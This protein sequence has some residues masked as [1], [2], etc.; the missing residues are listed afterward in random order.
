MNEKAR[1]ILRENNIITNGGFIIGVPGETKEEMMS[2]ITFGTTI[3]F[4]DFAILRAY[5]STRWSDESGGNDENRENYKKF[6]EGW[7]FLHEDPKLVEFMHK[8]ATFLA[9]FHPKRVFSFFSPDD[10]RRGFCQ[11][12]YQ[13]Y[14]EVLAKRIYDKLKNRLQVG[15]SRLPWFKEPEQLEEGMEEYRFL[16][17]GTEEAMD[18]PAAMASADMVARASGNGDGDGKDSRRARS[19]AP[20]DAPQHIP[21]HETSRANKETSWPE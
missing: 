9:R 17:R 1:D 3:D 14:A 12:R 13:V 10:F 15:L 19:G 18:N 21:A 5:P 6:N 20:L 11:W 16:P 4:P 8:Y 2:T 7:C